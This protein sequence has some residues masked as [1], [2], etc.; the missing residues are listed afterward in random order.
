MG[1]FYRDK[2]LPELFPGTTEGTWRRLRY[3]RKGPPF[4]IVGRVA[5]YREKDVYHWAQIQA[6]K[7]EVVE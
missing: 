1:D 3:Q 6:E 5:F 2:D 7:P 4:F